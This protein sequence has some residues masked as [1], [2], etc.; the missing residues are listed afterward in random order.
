[1]PD[2]HS[3]IGRR[4]GKNETRAAILQ[5]TKRRF[6]DAGYTRGEAQNRSPI[7]ALVNA[8]TAD[9]AEASLLRDLR[10]GRLL[11]PDH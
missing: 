2:S 9:A 11:L 7:P 6:G 4:P 8:A 10:M 3:T 5:A 1:M